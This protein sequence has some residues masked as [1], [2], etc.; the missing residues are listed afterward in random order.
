MSSLECCIVRSCPI[1]YLNVLF[2]L[3]MLSSNLLNLD[4]SLMMSV[5]APQSTSRAFGFPVAL[6]LA[7]TTSS[8]GSPEVPE[9]FFTLSVLFFPL[10]SYDACCTS[11]PVRFFSRLYYNRNKRYAL[12]G[13]I[14][15]RWHAIEILVCVQSSWLSDFRSLCLVAQCLWSFARRL[16]IPWMSVVSLSE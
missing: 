5:V 15:N 13:H 7:C 10:R 14:E 1:F 2:C 6:S 9:A 11:V 8:S 12:V 4:F 3:V 16:W